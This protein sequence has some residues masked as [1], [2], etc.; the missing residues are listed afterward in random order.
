MKK[1]LTIIFL[2]FGMMMCSS[3]KAEYYFENVYKFQEYNPDGMKYLFIQDYITSLSYLYLN[4]KSSHASDVDFENAESIKALR[5]QLSRENIN[6]R[7]ARN[8]LKKYL[9]SD[10]KMM[11]KAT[12][13]T[14]ALCNQQV[15]INKKEFQS[16]E[17]YQKV[18]DANQLDE[19][20]RKG[21][22]ALQDQIARERKESLFNLM[23]TTLLVT[24]VMISSE[25]DKYGDLT[26]LAMTNV[27]RQALLHRL[28]GEFPGELYDGQ[29]REGQSFLQASVVT[30]RMMLEDREWKTFQG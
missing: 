27:Q 21:F 26:V 13:M 18:Q 6:L 25:P 9:G 3:A 4:E 5:D 20:F 23:D 7:I 16:L 19:E 22:F 15:E 30:L 8:F 17:Q 10:N 14:I 29:L 1:T 28:K 2:L 11:Q 24:K 12:D